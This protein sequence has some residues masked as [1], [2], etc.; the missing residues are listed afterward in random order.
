M[1]VR[2]SALR[3]RM[4]NQYESYSNWG[5]RPASRQGSAC[6][7]ARRKGILI[8]PVMLLIQTCAADAG[9]PEPSAVLYGRV[10]VNGVDIHAPD[11]VTV[12]ARVD[13]VPKAIG[14]Y[15]MGDRPT[16]GDDYV[17]AMRLESLFDGSP[18]SDNAAVVGQTAHLV[19]KTPDGV[20]HDAGTYLLAGNGT[21][22]LRDLVVGSTCTGRE[23][24]SK[25]RCAERNGRLTLTVALKNGRPGDSFVVRLDG[26]ESKS[27]TVN[28]R[29]K[30]KAKFNDRP[31]GESGSATATWGCGA[32][33]TKAYACP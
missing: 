14:S 28:N 1:T 29:G 4:L 10:T 26:G 17:L 31:N 8:A 20:E 22:E 23:T 12:L 30:G 32:Q 16:A 21:V 3:R 15:H 24:I 5:P 13:G 33:N 19:V 27:G 18:Q 11:D 25:G 2:E 7:A 9:M 6:V